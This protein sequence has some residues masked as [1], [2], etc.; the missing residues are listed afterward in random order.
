MRRQNG[1]TLPDSN[2]MKTGRKPI[3]GTI[4]G[5]CFT[6]H[7]KYI[8]SATWDGWKCADYRFISQLY[9]VIPNK[10]WFDKVIIEAPIPGECEMNDIE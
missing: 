3:I 4:G 10:A 1:W 6:F 7:T 9:D 8:D 2:Y 5:C